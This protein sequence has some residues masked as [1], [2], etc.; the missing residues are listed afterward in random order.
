MSYQYLELSFIIETACTLFQGCHFPAKP[1]FSQLFWVFPAFSQPFEIP[2]LFSAVF[3]IG[4]KWLKNI[5]FHTKLPHLSTIYMKYVQV[6][7]EAGHLKRN[8]FVKYRSTFLVLSLN[9]Q[10]SRI[11]VRFSKGS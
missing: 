11:L 3:E 10:I 2:S 1:A 6:V 8:I 7:D 9:Y 5:T 4:P